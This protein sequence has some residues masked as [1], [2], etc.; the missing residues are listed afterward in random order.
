MMTLGGGRAIITL[1]AADRDH[2]SCCDCQKSWEVIIGSDLPSL[3]SYHFTL[4]V[5]ERGS[6]QAVVITYKT[7]LLQSMIWTNIPGQCMSVVRMRCGS[8]PDVMF[9]S[10]VCPSLRESGQEKRVTCTLGEIRMRLIRMR[11]CATCH[12]QMYA[13]WGRGPYN[14]DLSIS[15]IYHPYI[16]DIPKSF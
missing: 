11:M 4:Q 16:R 10:V 6:W 8:H 15:F 7:C 3:H 13:T 9:V 1:Q 12:Q 5:A 2:G 14:F